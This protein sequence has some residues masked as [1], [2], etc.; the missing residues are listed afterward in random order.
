MPL[1]ESRI[2]ALAQN[3]AKT[4]FELAEKAGGQARVEETL[5]ELEGLLAMAREDARIGEFFASRVI[6]SE[7]KAPVL[8]RVLKGRV[9][10][11]TYRFLLILSSNGRLARLP[12]IVEAFDS[13][14]QNAFGR[15]EVDVYTATPLDEGSKGAITNRLRDLLKREPVIHSYVDASLIG[16]VRV[17]IGDQL[18]DGSVATR[19]RKMREHFDV[20]GLSAVKAAVE[21]IVRGDP[22]SNGH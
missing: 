1:I 17:Q 15:V 12:S 11:L 14:V 16:G 13:L 3:Y 22:A 20:G 8:E 10:D 19:L 18:I 6:A 9:S 7:K 5:G 4:L 2:D 21:R